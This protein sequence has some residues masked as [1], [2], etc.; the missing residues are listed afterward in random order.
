MVFVIGRRTQ[1]RTAQHL[2]CFL[3][4]STMGCL[5]MAAISPVA[6]PATAIGALPSIDEL[7]GIVVTALPPNNIDPIFEPNQ[8]KTCYWSGTIAQAT[9]E[10]AAWGVVF[11]DASEPDLLFAMIGFFF[12]RAVRGPNGL[13]RP[14]KL[15][16]SPPNRSGGGDLKSPSIS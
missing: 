3:R 8:P 14:D 7:K 2:R 11:S 6:S 10:G 4:F 12:V 15:V 5:P 16:P 1:R 9:F 13:G